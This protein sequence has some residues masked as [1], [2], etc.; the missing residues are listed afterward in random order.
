MHWVDRGDEPEGLEAIRERYTPRWVSYHRD[1]VGQ[2]PN[3]SR[4]QDFSA[5]LGKRFSGLCAYCEKSCKGEVDHFRPKSRCPDLVYEWTN[6]LFAC[7]E[8]NQAKGDKWPAQGY[9]DPCADTEA[10]HPENYF[11]FNIETAHIIP[12]SDLSAGRHDR[13]VK[14]IGAL[15][16]NA[17]HH[18][19]TRL[20][21]LD[22]LRDRFPVDTQ[23]RTQ[24]PPSDSLRR[25][26]VS[27]D[28]MLS[29]LTRAWLS[30]RGYPTG[31]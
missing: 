23:V 3:D 31:G 29:S 20:W 15:Q 30:E 5:D 2:S 22:F 4:W 18:L 24:V 14:M 16:L 21:L 9:V 12:R 27:R 26:L 8:C 6:W 7:H 1:R 13:A 19:R 10:E 11:G 17:A 28:T 25:R